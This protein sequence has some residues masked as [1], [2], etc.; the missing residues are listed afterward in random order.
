MASRQIVPG[1]VVGVG[2][3]AVFMDSFSSDLFDFGLQIRA[4][5]LVVAAVAVV[6]VSALTQWPASRMIS[7]LDLAKLVRERS[8]EDLGG[9][10]VPG[11]PCDA[12]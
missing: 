3:S 6:L 10:G 8:Q 7:R 4:R 9:G 11:G 2:V 1:L 5:T 12:V